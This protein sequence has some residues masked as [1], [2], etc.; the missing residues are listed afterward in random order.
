MFNKLL[1]FTFFIYGTAV[2]FSC[3]NSSN[4]SAL[5]EIKSSTL[6]EVAGRSVTIYNTT[7]DFPRGTGIIINGNGDILTC[8]HVVVGYENDLM[9]SRDG[10][11]LIPTK[12]LKKGFEYDLAILSSDITEFG[13]AEWEDREDL[14]INQDVYVIASPYG[15]HKSFLKGYISHTARLNADLTYSKIPF[16]QTQGISFEGVSGAAVFL[17]N[18]KYIGINRS[19]FG[20]GTGNGIGLVLPAETVREFLSVKK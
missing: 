3:N 15:L 20:F 7:V 2:I 17:N 19:T 6:Q 5:T 1:L 10:I 18:G 9:I 12:V 8:F 11:K 4:H 13:D 14:S 16:V